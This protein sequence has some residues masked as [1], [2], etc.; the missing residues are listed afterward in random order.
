[1]IGGR[2]ETTERTIMVMSLF[3]A[4]AAGLFV[5]A[6]CLAGTTAPHAVAD[7]CGSVGGPHVDVS[8][9]TDPYGPEM[10]PMPGEYGPP[11]GPG[12]EACADVGRRISV[13]G[14][15]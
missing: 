8:G 11:E 4:G 13:G 14:C 10:G 2:V 12:I 9:C 7:V 3:R 15:V 1:M 5:A 6:A